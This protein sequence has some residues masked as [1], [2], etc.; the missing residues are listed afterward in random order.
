MLDIETKAAI[1]LHM[2]PPSPQPL[3]VRVLCLCR[4]PL[5]RLYQIFEAFV[6]HTSDPWMTCSYRNEA[7]HERLNSTILFAP[8]VGGLFFDLYRGIVSS[9]CAVDEFAAVDGDV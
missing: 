8:E 4:F 5:Q 3:L 9:D 6:G 7:F 2:V 1:I